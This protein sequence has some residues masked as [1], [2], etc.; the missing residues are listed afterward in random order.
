MLSWRTRGQCIARSRFTR[1]GIT[2]RKS[3]DKFKNQSSRLQTTGFELTLTSQ[4]L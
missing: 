3:T 4:G 1:T 2:T